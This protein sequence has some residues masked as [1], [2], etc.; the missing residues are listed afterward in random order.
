MSKLIDTLLTKDSLT[1]NG[2]STNSTALNSCVDLFFKIGALRGAEKNI[3]IS[4]FTKAFGEDPL[5]AMKILFW[6]RDVRGGAGER[7]TFREILRY[8]VKNKTE[9]VKNNMALIPEYGRWDDMLYLIGTKLEKEA[10]GEI[11]CALEGKNGLCAKWMPRGN[12]KNREK[13][14]WASV[15]RKYLGLTPKSYRKLLSEL[16]NTV[17]QLMC[18][19]KFKDINY[20]HVP[21]KAMSDYMRAFERN[22][23]EGFNKYLDSLKNGDTKINSGAI[24][25]YDVTKNLQHGSSVGAVEQWKSLP[26]YMEGSKERV[27]P[28]VDVSGSMTVPAGNN[29]NLSCLD[30]SVSLGLYISERNEGP[31]KDAFFT[32]SNSPQLQYLKGDLSD[33]FTQL[34][35]AEWGGS[36]NIEATFKTLLDVSV[37]NNVSAEEM[38]TMILILSDMEF[39]QATSMGWSQAE[40]GWNPTVQEMIEK[41]YDNAGYKMPKI[42]YWNIQSRR[43]NVPVKFDKQGTALVS[44]FSPALLTA[45]LSGN[46]ITPYSIMSDVINSERYDKIKI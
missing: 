31:F 11:A 45:L 12:T 2:M 29:P 33:R 23:S 42:V 19:K 43:D 34:S 13:K 16:S 9:V 7:K 25:P 3:K 35:M 41:M 38:P 46:E 6:A 4:S 14:R 8:L 10:L 22:D 27:L 18:S 39:N 17:E 36:T 20:S 28:V 1:E 26:N 24:Y 44:G 40:S 5:T 15:I 21:S 32:F 37:N 30:V